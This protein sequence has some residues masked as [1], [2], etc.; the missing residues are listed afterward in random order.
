VILPLLVPSVDVF[1][2]QTIFCFLAIARLGYVHW[3][4]RRWHCL[5]KGISIWRHRSEC[6]PSTPPPIIS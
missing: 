6:K 5:Q 1:I 4:P 3:R 2:A